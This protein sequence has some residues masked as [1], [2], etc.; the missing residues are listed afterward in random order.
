MNIVQIPVMSFPSFSYDMRLGEA[1]VRVK[2]NFAET[3][4]RWFISLEN[5]ENGVAYVSGVKVVPGV[6]LFT[7]YRA[8]LPEGMTGDIFAGST[9]LSA[10]SEAIESGISYEA[11][12]SGGIGLFYSGGN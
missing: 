8:H 3:I 4:K 6:F 5:A 2:L 7:N 11:L 10:L 1:Y 12:T 9:D